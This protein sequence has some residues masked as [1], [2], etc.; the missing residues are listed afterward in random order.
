[1]FAKPREQP[2]AIE[3]WNLINLGT[4]IT[5]KP[6]KVGLLSS[7]AYGANCALCAVRVA[8]ELLTHGQ[9]VWGA[10]LQNF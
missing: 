5:A 6:P 9:G 10:E 2:R 8:T 7:S 3:L 1:M 4:V